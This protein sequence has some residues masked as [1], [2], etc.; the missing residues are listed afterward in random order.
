MLIQIGL[1]SHRSLPRARFSLRP[2]S[3]RIFMLVSAAV[4]G[5]ALLSQKP[6]PPSVDVTGF[7]QGRS[8]GVCAAR[9]PGCAGMSLISLSMIQDQSKISGMYRCAT[10]TTLCRNLDTQGNIAVGTIRGPGV[11]LR[12]M[13]DDVSS[14]IFNGTFSDTAGAGAYICMQGGGT[15]DRGFWK[16]RRSFGPSPPPWWTG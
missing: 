5:C 1:G 2:A 13:F 7:W 15:V 4:A 3:L 6:P 11:S 16:V 10:G 12:I 14:C 9:M 8:I